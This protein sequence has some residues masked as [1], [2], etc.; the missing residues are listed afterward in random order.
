ME[1]AHD[2]F[3]HKT[4][5]GDYAIID[6]ESEDN[7]QTTRLSFALNSNDPISPP[8]PIQSST[9]NASK[10]S[11]KYPSSHSMNNMPGFLISAIHSRVIHLKFN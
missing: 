6:L 10:S 8:S 5:L 7:F 11:R 9:K 1:S 3:K 2:N 4:H